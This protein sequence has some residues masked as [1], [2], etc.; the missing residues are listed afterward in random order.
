[1][2]IILNYNKL[3]MDYCSTP[4]W[5]SHQSLAGVKGRHASVA[6][7]TTL[8]YTLSTGALLQYL[9]CSVVR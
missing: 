1:M 6:Q 5:L 7:Y 2:K 3:L 8:D 4:P 9:K